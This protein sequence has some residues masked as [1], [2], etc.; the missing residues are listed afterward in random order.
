[1][2]ANYQSTETLL[3][4]KEIAMMKANLS[5][6]AFARVTDRLSM[7]PEILMAVINHDLAIN[8]GQESK[9]NRVH[10]LFYSH[11]DQMCFVAIQDIKTG[12]VITLLP[13]D[14]HNNIAWI[15]SL[16]SQNQ[17]KRLMLQGH[18]LSASDSAQ[19]SKPA[20]NQSQTALVFKISAKIT[21][22]YGRYIKKINVGTWPCKPYAHDIDYLIK[23]KTFIHFLIN[24]MKEKLAK[25]NDEES[26]VNMIS[27]KTG[28]KGKETYYPIK[29]ILSM[30]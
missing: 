12:T 16:E 8:I 27:I 23:D 11:S 30:A 28:N 6:H 15:V 18:N 2:K 25:L 17:A 13:I 24:K 29:D 5:H 10:K 7:S 26:F 22:D 21:D 4:I 19:V 14:Y 20:T 9:S 3:I 1:M